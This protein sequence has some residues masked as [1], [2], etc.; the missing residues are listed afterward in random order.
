MSSNLELKKTCNFCGEEY[1]ARTTVTQYCSLKCA[2]KSYKKRKA[3]EKILTATQNNSINSKQS[4]LISP[5][6]NKEYLSVEE[7]ASLM[8]ISRTTAYRFCVDKIIPCLK[9]KRKIFIRRKDVEER[10]DNAEPYV[11]TNIEREAVTE[12]Y[13]LKEIEEIYKFSRSHIYKLINEK[14]IPKTEFR[15]KTLVSK[16]HVNRHFKEFL[17]DQSITEWYSVQDIENKFEM[18]MNAVYSFTS[19]NKIPKKTENGKVFFSK[20][21]VDAYLKNRVPDPT[22][23]EWYTMKEIE[24]KYSLKQTYVSNLIYKNPI[25][26]VRK[27]SNVLLSKTHFDNLI[28]EKEIIPEYYTVEEAMQKYNISRD[29]LY[30]HITKNNIPKVKEGRNVKIAKKE[31]DFLFQQKPIIL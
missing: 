5:I 30:Y 4:E 1:I 27:G 23:T 14:R 28:K 7:L 25:P 19:N 9:I 31:L 22:I 10:F 16:K 20:E 24:E 17:P 26:K 29:S 8:G 6:P 18:T 12:F 3:E 21:H 11:V 2:Q 13:T 15:G